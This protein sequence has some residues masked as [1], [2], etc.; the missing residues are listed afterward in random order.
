M[1]N[2]AFVIT[3]MTICIGLVAA[4]PVN[5][6]PSDK[7]VKA[8]I[9]MIKDMVGVDPSPKVAALCKE[10]KRDAAMKAA[11]AGE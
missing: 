2:R 7:E 9:Q 10:G 3:S 4:A 5:A 11:M 8:C 1:L 6:A